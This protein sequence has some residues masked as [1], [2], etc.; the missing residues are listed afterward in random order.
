MSPRHVG[1]PFL[2][3]PVSSGRGRRSQPRSNPTPA[4]TFL[5]FS[6]RRSA[7]EPKTRRAAI[8]Y[9]AR[10]IGPGPEVVGSNPTPA[11][12]FLPFSLRRSAHEPKTRRA[13]ISYSARFIGP[14]PEVVGS[15]PTP[16][17]MG[18]P[19]P[20]I[21]KPFLLAPRPAYPKSGTYYPCRAVALARW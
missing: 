4:T 5:P 11:T 18:F 7:H 9:S 19:M 6:L 12:T 15:N 3:R 14:G 8:S 1:L 17:T 10:L 20:N 16:A 2:I 13:A 21:G